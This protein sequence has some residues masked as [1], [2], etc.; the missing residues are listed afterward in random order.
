MMSNHSMI[1]Y[2]WSFHVLDPLECLTLRVD[3]QR[4]PTATS[5]NHA[6]LGGEPIARQ[7][8]DVPVSH[9]CWIHH[10]VAELVL[11]THGNHE[12]LELPDPDIIDQFLTVACEERTHV[13]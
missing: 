13:R 3:H 8:L 5:H 7:T 9:S 6:V 11:L 2:L 1:R 4:P 12:L 10:E